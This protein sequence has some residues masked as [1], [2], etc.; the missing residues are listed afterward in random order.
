MSPMRYITASLWQFRRMHLAVAA[1]VAV[2]TAVITGALLVGDSVRGSL[3][4]LVME[5]L[6]NI[7]TVLVAEQPFRAELAEELDKD[8][9]DAF[10]RDFAPL[11]LIP[12]SMSSTGSERTEQATRLSILGVTDEFWKL[13][14]DGPDETLTGDEAFITRAIADELHAK[15]GDELLLRVAVPSNIPSDSTLGEKADSTTVRRLKV[16]AIL[17]SGIAR[18]SLQP[19]QLE[20][21]NVFLP[22]ATLQRL[23]EI[24]GKANVIAVGGEDERLVESRLREVLKPKLADF[25]LRVEQVTIGEPVVSRFVQL[26]AERLV[27][28]PYLVEVVEKEFSVA[29]TQAVGTYLANSINLGEKKI[30]YSTVTGIDSTAELGPLRD[31]AGNALVFAENEIVLNDWAAARL[32]AKVGDTVTIKYYEPETTHGQL[33]ECTTEPLTVR[34]IAPLKT[35]DGQPTAVADQHFTPE[36]PGVTDERSISDW[37][38]PFKLVEKINQE[39]EDYWDE[40]RTT[41]KAFVSLSLAKKLWSTRWGSISA[42]RLP[43]SEDITA[44]NV[45]AK[46]TAAIDPAAL[47]MKWL[48]VKE[49]GLVASRGTTSFEG[50]FLGFS[51]FLMAS[52]VMLIA[53]LFRLGTE[54]RAAEV[55]ILSAIGW[56][57]KRLRRIWLIEAAVVAVIGA[58]LGSIAGIAYAAFMI[59]GLTTWWVA[60]TVTPFLKLHVNATSL[61]IGFAIGT[62]VALVTI[63]W[64]LRK[65]T[66]LAPRQL[67][68]GDTSDPRD[69][70]RLSLKPQRPWLPAGLILAAIAVGLMAMFVQLRDEAQAGAFFVSGALVLTALLIWLR[71]KLRQPT[72]TAAVT[73]S[74]AGLTLRNA[75][76]SPSRTIL[77]VGLAAVASFLIVALSAF[78]LAPTEGGTGGFDLIATADLPVFF[79]LNTPEGRSELG[80]SADDEK[81]L[82]GVEVAS[83]R[84]RGGEDASCLNLYQ[85]SQPRVVGVPLS[86]Y[87]ENKFTWAAQKEIPLSVREGLREGQSRNETNDPPPKAPPRSTGD[88]DSSSDSPWKLLDSMLGD[89]ANNRPIVPV[90]LDKNT[91]TYSLHLS[92]IGAQFTIRDSFDE[93]ITLEIVGLLAGSILQGNVLL[94]ETNF[95]RLFPDAA[96]QKMFL[97]RTSSANPNKLASLL[98]TRLVDHGFDTVSATQRLAEFMAV[99]NTYLST[100]QSLGALGLLMGTVGLAVAQLRSV[101]ERR[102]ELALLRSAGFRRRRLAEMVLG[103]NISLLFAGLGCGC[104]AA[105]VAT[106]PHWAFEQADIPWGTLAL[107]LAIVAASGVAA[108]WLAVRTAIRAP[109][110]PALRGD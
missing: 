74:L 72:F 78:R 31:E 34:Q 104:C 12:G 35:A 45:E 56:G 5:R 102:G 73:L 82:V 97:I 57:T 81:S 14:D 50:L 16:T 87:G 85:T 77:S 108:G 19:S 48:P 23:L 32:E 76:R 93:P 83:F 42:L 26:S 46:L 110:L 52:A 68:T 106:L 37:D 92:G 62:F 88:G 63:F 96:G 95:L 9:N 61:A 65:L 3:R 33:I 30:P 40:Y 103:E 24:P 54:S 38:L 27:L 36:L 55:G 8:F 1:G 25:G 28:A 2:A 69:V 15:V 99:Q 6:G 13:G 66:K 47:G 17:N 41:P 90:V 18:F 60:A 51:F 44:G 67:L 22:L 53:L 64:S 109:L 29:K 39:D 70:M 58:A 86:F 98:E 84:V 79:D 80:F 7:D 75:R 10:F 11:L 21:R 105:L 91:A 107:L 59:H 71:A 101:I 100:F 89:D 20:P 43:V 94:S 49:Q 4:D